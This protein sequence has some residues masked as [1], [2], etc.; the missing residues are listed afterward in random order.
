VNNDFDGM[1][2]EIIVRVAQYYIIKSV[3]TIME[4]LRGF[5]R[6]IE[7]VEEGEG[8]GYL[9]KFP[10]VCLLGLGRCGTN[11]ALGVSILA[12]QAKLSFL[13]PPVKEAQEPDIPKDGRLEE[14]NRWFRSAILRK[15]D[16]EALYL[17]EPIVIVGDLDVDISG[18]IEASEYNKI[19]E[20]KYSK[21]KMLDLSDIHHG[22][23][24]N[25]P[26]IGQYLAKVVLN[27]DSSTFKDHKWKF[28]HSYL[29]NSPG[30]KENGSRVFFFIF[31]AGGGTGSGMAGEF[32]LAQQ[33]S[34]HTRIHDSS[35]QQSATDLG[36]AEPESYGFEPIFS[37]GIAILPHFDPS[38]GEFSQAIHVNAGRLICKYLSE[39]WQ[40]SQSQPEEDVRLRHGL[41]VRPWN[42][43]MLISNNIMRYVEQSPEGHKV[44]VAQ[45]EQYANQ[46]VS[47]Q[48]FNI[49]T[50]QALTTDYDQNYLKGANIERGDTIRLD[51][52][53]LYMSLAGPVAI[54]YAES[55]LPAKDENGFDIK[56]MFY[57]SLSLPSLNKET[58]AVEGISILP[59]AA[60]KYE[61]T[62]I[63]FKESGYGRS[64]MANV[65]CFVKC[66]STVTI[67]SSP[68]GSKVPSK[69]LSDLKLALENVFPHTKIKRYALVVGA[70]SNLSL[71][72]IIA[73]SPCLSD[74]VVTLLF[75]YLKRCFAKEAFRS[76]NL[77][78]KAIESYLTEREQDDKRLR[79]IL[80]ESED[81][82]EVIQANWE[83]VK[84]TSER[85][86]R[87]F[88]PDP[89]RFIP[90]DDILLKVE[91]VLNALRYIA[92]TLRHEG[93]PLTSADTTSW[94]VKK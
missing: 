83:E 88:L 70:S 87:Q 36:D 82:S 32:G 51:A 21:L 78:D 59:Q 44:D 76:S 27:K 49:L 4:H 73:K 16:K 61:E 86:Y 89:N 22:G 58:N 29:I 18:R 72:T 68:K 31:S 11:I 25:V 42:A 47:Q 53:D 64:G 35:T 55:V 13:T 69:A 65:K 71:T 40:F 52:N 56:E 54:A 91:D 14:L 3:D 66:S 45:M 8:S 85:R 63:Q 80:R 39:E 28:Y 48:I 62:L 43:L 50:A 23:A 15:R 7:P 20:A 17:V 75:A 5:G 1:G 46:Y 93:V 10:S 77:L 24:G 41:V 6:T 30:L 81:P 34:Y 9:P 19:L 74:E 57:R 33:Y 2:E 90:M 60:A 94:E 84:S 26:L 79:E 67:I 12:Y 37:A 38:E 92:K